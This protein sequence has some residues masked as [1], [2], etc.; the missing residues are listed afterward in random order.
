MMLF[1]AFGQIA[2]V[3][4]AISRIFR[5]DSL[6]FV[7]LNFFLGDGDV[8][9]STQTSLSPFLGSWHWDPFPNVLYCKR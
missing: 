7:L 4:K 3:W 1:S 9:A 6:A 8:D 5:P 2:S